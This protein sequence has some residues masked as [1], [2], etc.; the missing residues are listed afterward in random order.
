M[1]VSSMVRPPTLCSTLGRGD[2]IR[3]PWPAARITA[4]RWGVAPEG[5]GRSFESA[6]ALAADL[7]ETAGDCMAAVPGPLSEKAAACP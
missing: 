7:A 1:A 4:A 5:M 2:F 6:V 3:V